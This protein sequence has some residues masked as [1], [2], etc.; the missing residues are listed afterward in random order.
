MAVLKLVGAQRYMNKKASPIV[1]L[2]GGL[3]D[4][5]TD[6]SLVTTLLNA[7]RVD[8]LNNFHPMFELVSD[9]TKV[10]EP[11]KHEAMVDPDVVDEPVETEVAKPRPK[12]TRK[13]STRARKSA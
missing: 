12:A 4:N 6:E 8:A 3:T 11:V 9:T 7:K 1:I 2:Q 10:A 13:K 5:I